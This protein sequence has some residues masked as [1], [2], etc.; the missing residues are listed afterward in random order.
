MTKSV[1]HS[2]LV[3][4]LELDAL[5]QAQWRGMQAAN[6]A[7]AS[8]YFS[9]DFARLIAARRTDTHALVLKRNG[10]TAGFLPLHL[11]MTGIA[12]PLGGPLGDHHGL[13]TDDPGLDLHSALGSSPVPLFTYSGALASQAAGCDGTSHTEPSWV[14]DLHSGHEAWLENRRQA[15][16]K[17]MRNIRARQ[18]KLEACGDEVV[19][20]LD[21][22]RPEILARTFA[23]KREQYR[24]TGAFDVFGARWARHLMRDLFDHHSDELRGCMS[25]LEIGGELAAAHFGM[26]SQSVLHY[27]FPVYWSAHAH[28]GPGLQLLLEMA[29]QLPETGIESIHLGPGDFDFKHKLA[30]ASFQIA[31]GRIGRRSLAA[32]LVS[33][34]AGIDRWSSRL[35]VG[36]A[37]AWPGKALSRLDALAATYC[38]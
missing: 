3:P 19:F 36:R 23:T 32:G 28:L 18:R 8:P 29:K 9:L 24:R 5:Q 38:L 17:A 12:R 34:G 27:W 35:P 11:S 16:A 7:L 15:D 33:L 20:R 10:R 25:T 6:P 14:I 2:E 4:I 13:I 30:N 26:R 31:E 37:S 1:T 22:R 21:D